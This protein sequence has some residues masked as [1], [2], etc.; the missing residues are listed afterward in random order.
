[1]PADAHTLFVIQILTPRDAAMPVAD[2]AADAGL[3]LSIIAG[4]MRCASVI[5]SPLH[6]P[7]MAFAAAILYAMPGAGSYSDA[8]F[9][10]PFPTIIPSTL[11]MLDLPATARALL[12]LA[13]PMPPGCRPASADAMPLRCRC[14]A[15]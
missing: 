12:P 5:L 14:D 1:M 9:H 4:F 2:A 6:M 7:A 15:Y 3:P 13:P 8:V 10:S 11:D